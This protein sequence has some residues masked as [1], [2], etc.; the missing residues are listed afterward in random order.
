M[1]AE[2]RGLG[3]ALALLGLSGCRGAGEVDSLLGTWAGPLDCATD[4][5]DEGQ[6]VT[7][8]YT[9]DL[10]I[11]LTGQDE[12]VYTGELELAAAYT[13][14]SAEIVDEATYA[15]TLVQSRP[16]GSQPVVIQDATCVD[17]ARTIDGVG[18]EEGCGDYTPAPPTGDLRWDGAD[19]LTV[20]GARCNGTL[21]R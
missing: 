11:S 4:V 19:A 1:N 21:E 20:R 7:L 9:T 8:D 2:R 3:L 15:I 12:R 10:S 13:W 6:T 17:S 18:D 14:Q 5:Q 16:Q